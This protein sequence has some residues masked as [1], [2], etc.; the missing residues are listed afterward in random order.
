[1]HTHS[2]GQQTEQ[3]IRTPPTHPGIGGAYLSPAL[4]LPHGDHRLIKPDF[5][6][7]DPIREG[8]EGLDA[9]N[10]CPESSSNP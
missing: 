6:A 7:M 3:V 10:D 9:T 2:W 5:Q 1:M 8:A 4:P